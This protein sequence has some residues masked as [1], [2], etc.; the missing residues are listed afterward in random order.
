MLVFFIGRGSLL[1]LFVLFAVAGMCTGILMVS[2]TTLLTMTA[3]HI[4]RKKGKRVDGTVFAMNSFAIKVGQAIAS[5]LV[6]VILV[7]TNYIPNSFEQSE[8]ALTGILASRSILP[9]VLGIIG[10]IVV[11]AF[12]LPKED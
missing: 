6:S 8:A 2:I 11:L 3:D 1:L 7:V 9:A 10:L 4:A 12:R 5:G